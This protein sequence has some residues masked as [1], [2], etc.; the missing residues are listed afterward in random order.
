MYPN[1]AGVT[2]FLLLGKANGAEITGG[3]I[4]TGAA[5]GDLQGFTLTAVATEVDPPFFC[6]IPDIAG[7][8]A[9]TPA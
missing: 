7:A 8:T 3:T 2:K 9:I 5:A 4:V 6:T 1:G